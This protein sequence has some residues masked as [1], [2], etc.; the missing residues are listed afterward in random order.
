MFVQWSAIRSLTKQDHSFD[1]LNLHR[2][3]VVMLSASFLSVVMLAKDDKTLP[4]HYRVGMKPDKKSYHTHKSAFAHVFCHYNPTII[5][6]CYQNGCSK[7]K[8]FGNGLQDLE[9]QLSAI[10]N[11]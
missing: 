2:V 5:C 9:Q 6:I 8:K 7:N 11:K 4:A 3:W 10:T 1:H